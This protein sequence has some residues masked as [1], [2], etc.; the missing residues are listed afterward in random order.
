MLRGVGDVDGLADFGGVQGALAPGGVR[1]LLQLL[2][3]A[4]H[5]DRLP[6]HQDHVRR[7][8]GLYKAGSLL[9]IRVR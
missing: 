8:Q 9:E 2:A 5:L 6:V 4:P 1:L 7:V 3:Q